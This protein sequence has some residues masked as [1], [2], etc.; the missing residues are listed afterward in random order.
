VIAE[1][2]SALAGSVSAIVDVSAAV[3]GG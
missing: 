2:S 3:T 1:G